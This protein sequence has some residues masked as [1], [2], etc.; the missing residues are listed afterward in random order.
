MPLYLLSPTSIDTA[1]V[2]CL[3]CNPQRRKKKKNSR[4]CL[5][6]AIFTLIT[7]AFSYLIEQNRAIGV[8][9]AAEAGSTRVWILPL[10]A[11]C[12]RHN[13]PDADLTSVAAIKL[14]PRSPHIFLILIEFI[15]FDMWGRSVVAALN[16]I[17]SNL[18]TLFYYGL[19]ALRSVGQMFFSPYLW[20]LYI[21]L[22]AR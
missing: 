20:R 19:A 6:L 8:G 12:S 5:C 15:L 9:R 21:V 2:S 11:W 4:R 3:Q 18:F 7:D 17:S 13:K 10:F 16:N 22:L 14:V 1:H